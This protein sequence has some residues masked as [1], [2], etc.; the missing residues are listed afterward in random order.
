MAVKLADV[1]QLI[2]HTLTEDEDVRDL[3]GERVFGAHFSDADAGKATYPL[4]IVE[5]IGGAGRHGRALHDVDFVLWTYSLVSAAEAVQ[6][7]DACYAALASEALVHQGI[8]QAGYARE[9]R[10][11]DAGLNQQLR[12]HYARGQWNAITAG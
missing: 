5:F 3:V 7:Y 11:P 12:A 8:D 10:R 2:R 4:V 6:V 1:L 9:V